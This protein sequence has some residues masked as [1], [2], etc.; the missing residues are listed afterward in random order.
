MESV[1]GGENPTFACKL[2]KAVRLS[3]CEGVGL[4][5]FVY[6]MCVCACSLCDVESSRGF[7]V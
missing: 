4:W 2:T 5:E 3:C 1:T 7:P 6:G